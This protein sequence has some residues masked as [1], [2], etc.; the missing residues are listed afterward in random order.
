MKKLF[1]IKCS[2]RD[3]R[4]AVAQQVL[5]QIKNATARTVTL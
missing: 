2:G 3:L 5:E 4:I 1:M